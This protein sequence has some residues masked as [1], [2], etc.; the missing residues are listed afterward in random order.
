MTFF[1]FPV[2]EF[3]QGSMTA[4]LALGNVYSLSARAEAVIG[5]VLTS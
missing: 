5:I 1:F 4:I 3:F 2:F